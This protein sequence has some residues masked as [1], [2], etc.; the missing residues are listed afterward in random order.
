MR[1]CYEVTIG[2]ADPYGLSCLQEQIASAESAPILARNFE[3]SVPNLYFIN[4]SVA[5]SFGRFMHDAEF[6]A[7]RLARHLRQRVKPQPSTEQI[8]GTI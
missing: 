1:Q 8:A 6:A 2:G 5:N 4:I 7:P 3:S